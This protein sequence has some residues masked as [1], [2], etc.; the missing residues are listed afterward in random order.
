MVAYKNFVN[1][2]ILM[3]THNIAFH[4][5]LRNKT[6]IKFKPYLLCALPHALASIIDM[7]ALC[8]KYS[9]RSKEIIN[10]TFSILFKK[11]VKLSISFQQNFLII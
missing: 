9:L 11:V 1:K 10:E 5:K 7:S 3:R 4:E 2:V 6:I 8:K